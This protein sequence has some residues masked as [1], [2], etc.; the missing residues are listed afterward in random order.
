MRLSTRPLR[1]ALGAGLAAAGVAGCVSNSNTVTGTTDQSL[2]LIRIVQVV[3]DAT[4]GVDVSLGSNGS[5]PGIPFG[6][7]VPSVAGT[8]GPYVLVSAAPQLTFSVAGSTTPFYNQPGSSITANGAFTLVALGRVTANAAP[9]ATVT[10]LADTVGATSTGVLIRLFNAVDYVASSKIGT[11]VDVY[12]YV[13]GSARPTTPDVAALAWNAR[14]AYLS[15]TAG[16]LQI[17]VFAAGAAST[18][19]PLF[20]T[21][22]TAGAN[23]IRTLVFRDPPAGSVA[24]TAGAVLT[25]SDQS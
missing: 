1:L 19:T 25:L 10:V 21:P 6:T 17:D 8:Y 11:P 22:L 3:S 7:Y 14:S 23:S 15:K 24:G 5:A 16:N 20:S 2:A 9:G 13:Q 4:G 18:G 12:V